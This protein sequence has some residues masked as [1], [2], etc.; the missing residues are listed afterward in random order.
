MLLEIPRSA[1]EKMV[2]KQINNLFYFINKEE[3]NIVRDTIE[4]ALERSAYSFSRLN[5]KYYTQNGETYFNPFHSGQYSI[6]LY[7]LSNSVFSHYPRERTLADRIYYLN[8]A[9][10]AVDLFYEVELPKIF[11]VDHP[12]GS[13]MGRAKYGNYFSFAQNCTVG[14]NKG[15]YPVI[16]ENVRMMSGA[17]ILGNCTIENDVIISANSYVKDID[18]PSCSIVF[19]TSPNLVIKSKDESYFKNVI[20][21]YRKA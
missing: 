17:T 14:N 4:E 8:K 13:V 15:I 16:G 19:G 6:F 20:V 12:L 18:I 2:V 11:F 21:N 3:K 5:S 1:L 9:L 10:N 7:Y